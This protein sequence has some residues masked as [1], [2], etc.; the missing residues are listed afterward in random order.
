MVER[1]RLDVPE[2][3]RLSVLGLDIAKLVFGE[4]V[5]VRELHGVSLEDNFLLDAVDRLVEDPYNL[6]IR[7]AS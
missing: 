2:L 4:L 3:G 7:V 1:E 6:L 5:F